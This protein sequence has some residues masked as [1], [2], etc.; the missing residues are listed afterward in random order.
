VQDYSLRS[1]ASRGALAI[2]LLTLGSMASGF[3]AALAMAATAALAAYVRR[4]SWLSTAGFCAVCAA[5]AAL[6]WLTRVEFTALYS[7]YAASFGGWLGAFLAYASWPLPQGVPGLLVL[8]LPWCILLART[9]GR[10]R[11]EPLAPFAIGLGLWTL[12]QACALA[13]ARAGVSGLVGSRYTE[14]L[15]WGLVANAVAIVLVFRGFRPAR[16]ARFVPWAAMA[17]WLA[18]VGGCEIWRSQAIY[19]P[20]LESFRGQTLEHERRLGTFMRTGDPGVIEGVGFPQIPY[21]SAEP[22]LSLLRD[23]G[24]QPMLPGPL[25]RDLV[26]DHQAALLPLIQDGPLALVAVRVLRGGRWFSAAGIAMLLT[27]GICAR[28]PRPDP[29]SDA[30]GRRKGRDDDEGGYAAGGADRR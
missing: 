27:A 21:I 18:C 24:V 5:I 20:Y 16:A 14:F 12:L 6:G 3:L 19:R 11:M 28:R 7:I 15:G 10:R 26:R 29:R 23:P 17:A 4:L 8:W 30:E 1:A 2:A 22:I 9:L 25:R 13:W